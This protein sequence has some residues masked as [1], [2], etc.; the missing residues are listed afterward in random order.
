MKGLWTNPAPFFCIISMRV[1]LPS[2]DTTITA[3][4]RSSGFLPQLRDHLL[5]VHDRHVD[6]HED[7]VDPASVQ[8]LQPLLAV[9]RLVD[10]PE[11][12][13]AEA[14]RLDDHLPHDGTVIHDEYVECHD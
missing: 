6:V 13:A 3:R 8:D 14:E 2:V 4:S 9:A 11:G 10:L 12:N 1:A 7:E 5:A